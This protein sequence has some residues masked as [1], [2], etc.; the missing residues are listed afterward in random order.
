MQT[1]TVNTYACNIAIIIS[2]PTIAVINK[3]GSKKI[4]NDFFDIK[5]AKLAKIANKVC[6]DIKFA[7][8]RIPKL[9]GLEKYEIISIPIKKGVNAFGA[10][11]GTKVFINA[12]FCINIPIITIPINIEKLNA[13]AITIWLVNVKLYKHIPIILAININKNKLNI[14]GKYAYPFVFICCFTNPKTKL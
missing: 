13:N 4:I 3:N 9:N 5:N 2:K 10:P 6:P 12:N 7:N 11:A 14:N 1:R 8:N